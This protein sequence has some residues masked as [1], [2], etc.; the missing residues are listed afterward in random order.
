M[1]VSKGNGG[2]GGESISYFIEFVFCCFVP[3]AP[4]QQSHTKSLI[5]SFSLLID[6]RVQRKV[7]TMKWYM[8]S[9][10]TECEVLEWLKGSSMQM[11]VSMEVLLERAKCGSVR[12]ISRPVRTEMTESYT[13]SSE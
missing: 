9:L 8:N 7:F 3:P 13:V 12:R 10:C 5:V 11:K 4:P 2:G 6:S 1:S